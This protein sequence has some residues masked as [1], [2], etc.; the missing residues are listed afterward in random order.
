[1]KMICCCLLT[2]FWILSAFAQ[3][4]NSIYKTTKLKDIA[5]LLSIKEIGDRSEGFYSLPAW[6][7]YPLIM[8]VN[9]NRIIDHIGIRLFNREQMQDKDMSSVFDFVE[10][11]VLELILIKDRTKIASKLNDDKVNLEYGDFP[12]LKKITD[13]L[14][15]EIKQFDTRE[16]RISWTDNVNNRIIYALS[17]PMYYELMLG[18]N[19]I[20]IENNLEADIKAQAYNIKVQEPVRKENMYFIP[21]TGYYI[22]PGEKYILETLNSNLYYTKDSDGT[23]SLLFDERFPVESLSNLMIS[24]D[25][26]NNYLLNITQHKYGRN[27]SEFTVPLKQWIRYC[28]NGGC[29]AYF[30]LESQDEH[31]IKATVIMENKKPAYNHVLYVVFD[32]SRLSTP[33]GTIHA[34]LHAYI[35]THNV[36]DLYN[37]TRREMPETNKKI[38]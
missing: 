18:M 19:K 10:R 14:S 27:V 9:Q 37:E 15:L 11:Y 33:D 13:S 35:P 29:V 31:R 16:Y 4:G 24:D 6:E 25:T 30:G 5:N 2:C 12:D 3:Q 20:E 21:Q 32:K 34:T 7:G 8:H 26:E 23:F 22:K 38:E 36:S 28:L 1:M 17:F